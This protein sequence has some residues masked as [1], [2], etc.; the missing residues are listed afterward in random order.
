MTT[1]TPAVP[2]K[3]DIILM[4]K[5]NVNNFLDTCKFNR[6]FLRISVTLILVSILTGFSM[7][8]FG[9]AL[10]NVMNE[11][12]FSATQSGLI[13]SFNTIGMMISTVVFSMLAD[14]IGPKKI[15][16]LCIILNSI[17]TG[18][19]GL[20]STMGQFAFTRIASGC[21]VSVIPSLIALLSEYSPKNNRSM[22]C[23]LGGCGCA[24]GMMIAALTGMFLLPATGNWRHLFFVA[25]IGIVFLPLV[26][27]FVPDS[28]NRLISS[29]QTAKITSILSKA[30][31]DFK[32][33]ANY[34]YTLR[35][36]KESG[37]KVS[38]VRLF[39]NGVARNTILGCITFFC[40]MA[41]L[42]G[43]GTW[44]PSMM[45]NSGYSVGTGITLLF[46]FSLGSVFV[47][48]FG[49][50]LA[51]KLGFKRVLATLL[52]VNCI[53]LNLFGLAHNMVASSI[54]IFV[55]GAACNGAQAILQPY[56]AYL[57]PEDIR[58]T[59][60]GIATLFGR[61][62]SFCA[63]L[64]G[65]ILVT[66]QIALQMDFFVFSCFAIVS[67]LCILLTKPPKNN[68]EV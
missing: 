54:M 17:F 23:A 14:K 21:G 41:V 24:I 48:P 37:G 55:A 57:Y 9:I 62:G 58:T 59:G 61:F 27:L 34:E 42:F 49:G 11:L 65:G 46:I 3:G 12:G 45:A 29:G 31:K 39:Q 28:M 32:P 64:L 19:T 66:N 1:V 52:F 44:L 68:L 10:N 35:D 43:T 26:I 50:K 18:C 38:I 2:Q 53:F 6:F 16:I 60:I 36:G 20:A 33:E 8:I 63:P 7:Y 40:N 67:C 5:L 22:I 15:V 4:K 25:F 13:S 51:D 30:S 47:S 56:I